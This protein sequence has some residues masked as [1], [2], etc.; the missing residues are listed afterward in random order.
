MVVS[1]LNGTTL[2]AILAVYS[3]RQGWTVIVYVNYTNI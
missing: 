1:Y 2:A 3:L